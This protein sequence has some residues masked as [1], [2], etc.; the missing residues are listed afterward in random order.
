M[1]T[2]TDSGVPHTV[3]SITFGETVKGDKRSALSLTYLDRMAEPD[4][5]IMAAEYVQRPACL[6]QSTP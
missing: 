3:T 2:E 4:E 5:E 6:L 1:L